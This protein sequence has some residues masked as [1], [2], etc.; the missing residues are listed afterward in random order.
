MHAT[1][2]GVSS[3]ASLL[4]LAAALQGIADPGDGDVARAIRTVQ[5]K[6]FDPPIS[7][8]RQAPHPRR[9]RARW[10]AIRLPADYGHDTD[11]K[12]GWLLSASAVRRVYTHS[13]LI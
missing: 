4:G 2:S 1:L 8:A 12:E 9:M 5:R 11:T 6:H 7:D 3:P 13:F 10:G